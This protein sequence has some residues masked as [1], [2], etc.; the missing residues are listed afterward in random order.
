MNAIV[1]VPLALFSLSLLFSRTSAG[2]RPPSSLIP[3]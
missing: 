3:P 1:N 2:V